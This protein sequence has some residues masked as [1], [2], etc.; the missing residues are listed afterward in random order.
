MTEAVG[1]LYAYVRLRGGMTMPELNS[2]E[3]LLRTMRREPAD[4]IPCCFMLFNALQQRC[5]EDAYEQAKAERDMGLDS[6]LFIPAIP[7]RERPESPNL[8]GLPV[9]LGS[10][11]KTKEWREDA[12]GGSPILHKEY[13]TPA[14]KLATSVPPTQGNFGRR[15]TARA[16]LLANKAS[17]P[18]GAGDW[19]PPGQTAVRGRGLD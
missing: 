3:R 15:R 2:R 10:S 13:D 5:R 12:S 1:P 7:R 4:H 17:F 18:R 16:P 8:R 11:V 6:Y 14:G 19:G 9:R